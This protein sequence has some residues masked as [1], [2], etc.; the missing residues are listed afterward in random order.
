MIP[1]STNSIQ[2]WDMSV[3]VFN[4]SVLALGDLQIQGGALA[5][6]YDRS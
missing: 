5:V 4:S 3:A 2:S 6:N 1:V